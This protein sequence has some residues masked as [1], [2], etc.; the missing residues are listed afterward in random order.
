[1][2]PGSEWAPAFSLES[3]GTT[4]VLQV[5]G[6][7]SELPALNKAKPVYEFGLSFELGSAQFS[8]SKVCSIMPRFTVCNQLGFTLQLVQAG[9]ED[10]PNVVVE[11]ADGC[12]A[13]F[14]W[15]D[16]SK[17]KQCRARVVP[18]IGTHETFSTAW[19][20]LI[21]PQQVGSFSMRFPPD[22]EGCHLNVLVEVRLRRA[23][24]FIIFRVEKEDK[25]LYAIINR[26]GM[27][28]EAWQQAGKTGGA[29]P[30]ARLKIGD[31][32]RVPLAWDRPMQERTLVLKASGV[33]EEML[34]KMDQFGHFKFGTG[35]A[36][37][38]AEVFADGSTRAVRLSSANTAGASVAGASSRGDGDDDVAFAR[39]SLV[40]KLAGVGVSLIDS[41][42]EEVMYFGA[43]GINLSYRMTRS[44]FETE[45][46]IRLLQIDNQTDN[47]PEVILAPEKKEVL[48]L[49]ALLVQKY[50]Y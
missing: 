21:D 8:R 22:A 5:S 2:L 38:T 50:K 11:L 42:M 44:D 47:G 30:P 14:H 6:A 20:G 17:L 35:A 4:G 43:L 31:G 15:V 9:L 37:I 46:K 7:P 26:S 29:A 39:Y 19:S 49:L 34:V 3:M 45:F 12:V 33:R 16:S 36:S 40:L 24:T 48:G 41:K 10:E 27:E 18:S 23:A 1:M 25:S 32:A 28:I 13:P